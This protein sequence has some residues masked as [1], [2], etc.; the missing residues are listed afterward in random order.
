MNI[1]N[2]I[3][4]N[5]NARFGGYEDL[6]H[7][8]GP[9][10]RGIEKRTAKMPSDI[11]LWTA[12]ACVLGS[13]ALEVFGAPK[14][15]KYARLFGGVRGRAPLASFVGLWVPSILLLGVYNKIVKVA[16]SDRLDRSYAI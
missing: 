4:S 6:E 1:D 13:L 15:W 3:H 5:E 2:P 11:F 7:K 9:V 16:G 12:G 10:A 14:R 8:E